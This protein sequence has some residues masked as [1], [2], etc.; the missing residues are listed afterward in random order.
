MS[1]P[2]LLQLLPALACAALAGRII[3]AC[4]PADR[5]DRRQL[6]LTWATSL[7][8]GW[9]GLAVEVYLADR[10][11]L[12]PRAWQ[13]AMPWV[14]LGLG[15]MLTLPGGMPPRH[16]PREQPLGTA[17]RLLALA[18]TIW[19][20]A[21]TRETASPPVAWLANALRVPPAVHL[22]AIAILVL[23]GLR[24]TRRSPTG[25]AA[26]TLALT[27]T[28]AVSALAR[29]AG[30]RALAAT[31]LVAGAVFSLS[32]LRRANKRS[33]LLALMSFGAV[34]VAGV[35]VGV[36]L[37]PAGLVALVMATPTARRRRVATRAG[38]AWI[39]GILCALAHGGGDIA[40][41]PAPPAAT[42]LWAW[43]LTA[44]CSAL[45]ALRTP[46]SQTAQLESID[47]PRRERVYLLLLLALTSIS[48]LVF[49]GFGTDPLALLTPVAALTVGLALPPERA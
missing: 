16:A 32:W 5:V 25:R 21:Q 4:L 18:L 37:G 28:P 22:A 36:A 49:H 38:M 34:P 6:P 9:G 45:Y 3:L 29:D 33:L 40:R 24:V 13:L 19:L 14:A 2:D 12:T 48:A 1:T 42:L 7:Y 11:G 17:A 39:A 31:L 35:P 23:H 41:P 43:L 26:L 46:V 27:L 15:R 8:L 44:L 10:L 30:P 47:P 20:L